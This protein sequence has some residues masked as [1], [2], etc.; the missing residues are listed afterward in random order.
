MG[1]DVAEDLLGIVNTTSP[2]DENVKYEQ[3]K[4]ANYVIDVLADVEE[5]LPPFRAVFSPHDNPN[6]HSDWELRE[7]ALDAARHGKCK[8]CYYCLLSRR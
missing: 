7:E 4:G 8:P 2:A 6:L 1:K 3:T 5:Y